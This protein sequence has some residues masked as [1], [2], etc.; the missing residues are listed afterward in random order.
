MR[1]NTTSLREGSHFLTWSF[2]NGNYHIVWKKP[3]IF[4]KDSC[5]VQ[6]YIVQVMFRLVI[7]YERGLLCRFTA[8]LW[9]WDAQTESYGTWDTIFCLSC[10][11]NIVWLSIAL[12]IPLDLLLV[13]TGNHSSADIW[14]KYYRIFRYN[15]CVLCYLN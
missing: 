1:K 13:V 9:G 12:D 4:S 5:H 11:K 10:A 7:I 2:R 14:T 6:F 8:S 15:K 3:V